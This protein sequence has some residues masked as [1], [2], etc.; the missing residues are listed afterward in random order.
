MRKKALLFLSISLFTSII[1]SQA[2][3]ENPSKPLSKNAGRVVELKEEIRIRDEGGEFYFEYPRNL[4][5]APDGSLFVEDRDQ[6]LQFDQ[7]GKFIHNF[8]KKGQG[9]GEF[10]FISDYCFHEP[11]IIVHGTDPYK[12]VW[13]DGKGNLVKE[14]K[15]QPKA[16]MLEFRL[17]YDDVYYFFNFDFP[18]FQGEDKIIDVPQN[19]MAISNDGKDVENPISFPV[20]KF[21]VAGGRGIMNIANFT[22]VPYQQ[23]FLF[24]SH[25]QEYLVKMYDV[26]KKQV[27]RSFR[28]EYKRVKTP[29]EK[30]G[31]E[32]KP[33]MWVGGKTY[34]GPPRQK[35]MNDI[36]DLF[37]LK[38]NLWVMTSTWEKKRGFL[39]DVF[40]SE[41][42]YIDSFFL[43]FPEPITPDSLGFKSMA[44][45]GGFLYKIGK[46]EEELY[47]IKKYKIDDK[48]N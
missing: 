7:S 32:K 6:L 8:F 43:K 5:I 38:D 1:L 25:T 16:R 14:F 26:Q 40:N 27:I 2:I 9:P 20:K 39:I 35:H 21:V 47:E 33:V 10:N 22:A 36:K 44:V 24:I 30:K 23:K 45:S 19:L 4:K 29:P 48:E 15:I 31:E 18:R 13:F 17:F 34:Y 12:I 41:G 28:R 46:N 3:I 37:V 42:K 11:F